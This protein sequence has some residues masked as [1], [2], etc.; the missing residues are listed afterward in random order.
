M[1]S[2]GKVWRG[3]AALA[4]D[5][6]GD[7]QVGFQDFLM[8]AQAYGSNDTRF[9][10]T[11]DG[12]VDFRDFLTFAQGYG[13]RNGSAKVA[14]V[15]AAPG[16]G[17][18]LTQAPGETEGE[19][20]VGVRLSEARQVWGYGLRVTYDSAGLELVKAEGVAG[21]MF[22]AERAADEVALRME[23]GQGEVLLSDFGPKEVEGQDLVRLTFR[24]VGDGTPVWV[25]V[26]EGQAA[27]G[28]G[29]TVRLTEAGIQ[30][31]GEELVFGLGQSR[32]NPFNASTQ[33]AYTLAEEG[34][35][36]LEV[37][38]VLGQRVATLVRGRQPAGVYT[39]VWDGRDDLGRHV[40]SGIYLYRLVSGSLAQTHRMLLLK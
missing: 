4:G 12:S 11:G 2:I 5:F 17:I 18:G 26:T 28:G 22:D 7:G 23:V 20:V 8:F 31:G 38:N 39:L 32:P 13:Q 6:N 33:I 14:A 21:S 36:R 3:E 34:D 30:V 25:R 16:A 1:R 40:A 24:Q 9:D 19:V 15:S 27:D 29:R 10:L 37:Y 35:A